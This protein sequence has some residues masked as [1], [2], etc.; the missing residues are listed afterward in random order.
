MDR[1]LVFKR[2]QIVGQANEKRRHAINAIPDVGNRPAL[3]LYAV[4]TQGEQSSLQG[5]DARGGQ[6]NKRISVA[7]KRVTAFQQATHPSIP[8]HCLEE[9]FENLA[10]RVV[11][12]R[13][14]LRVIFA[15]DENG[16]VSEPRVLLDESQ[17]IRDRPLNHL[18]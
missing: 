10:A 8:H 1:F 3:R 11:S 12:A 16:T 17:F 4:Q 15:I 9:S 14:I 2:G 5:L 18:G 13:H 6:G 7:P